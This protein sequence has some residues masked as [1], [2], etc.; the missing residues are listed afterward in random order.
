MEEGEKGKDRCGV[1]LS[2]S[3]EVLDPI[4]VLARSNQF[5]ASLLLTTHCA[6][7]E[8][9]VLIFYP[10]RVV[11]V[12]FHVAFLISFHF[13]ITW[14]THFQIFSNLLVLTSYPILNLAPGRCN[15]VQHCCQTL[16]MPIF[17]KFSH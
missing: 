3:T 13:G 1:I 10:P 14:G 5:S 12:N 11:C 17:I 7:F 9:F 2:F 16:F 4:F 8:N 15:I 6:Y